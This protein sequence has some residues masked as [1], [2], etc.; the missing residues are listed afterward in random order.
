MPQQ[1]ITNGLKLWLE[2]LRVKDKNNW[3]A[4]EIHGLYLL[5]FGHYSL[6]T[7]KQ[8]DNTFFSVYHSLNNLINARYLKSQQHIC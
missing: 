1:Q 2:C 4:A 6:S 8:D 5:A 7:Q 3:A